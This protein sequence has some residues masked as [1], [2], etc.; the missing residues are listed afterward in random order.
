[1]PLMQ[2]DINKQELDPG[3]PGPEVVRISVGIETVADIIAD[4]EQALS[5]VESSQAAD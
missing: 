4:L 3:F 1:M 2:T 5:G